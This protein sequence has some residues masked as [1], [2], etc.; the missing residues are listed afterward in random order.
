MSIELRARL[1]AGISQRAG[2]QSGIR[3]R[4]TI[5]PNFRD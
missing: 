1:S 5:R 4:S 3:L 2:L